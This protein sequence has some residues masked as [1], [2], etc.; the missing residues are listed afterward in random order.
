MRSPVGPLTG[1]VYIVAVSATA[2]LVCNALRADG[3]PLIRKPLRETR[4]FATAMQL[5]SSSTYLPSVS[6]PKGKT[7]TAKMLVKHAQPKI[8]DMPVHRSS[9]PSSKSTL[10][11]LKVKKPSKVT[12]GEPKI[13]ALFTTLKDAKSLFDT[14]SALFVDA[15]PHEDYDAEHI[16]GAISLYCA[17]FDS[18]Y[19]DVLGSIPKDR[20]IV[21]FCS[22]PECKE[23]VKLGDALAAR[24]H[25]RVVI[26]L[27]GLPGWKNAGYPV[28]AG[29]EST[30]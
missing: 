13:Q 17:Q 10:A 22:D 2:G 6:S 3:I 21:T 8:E 19:N 29:K 18:L 26:L 28:T 9:D 23:A 11:V 20:T 15:R 16:T 27:E 5:R 7:P 14:K 24:G 1:L 4:A 30:P 12:K 25:T